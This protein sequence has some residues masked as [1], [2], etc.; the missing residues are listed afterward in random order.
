M[1]VQM[2]RHKQL[3]ADASQFPCSP[4]KPPLMINLIGLR[5]QAAEE[6]PHMY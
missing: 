3:R 6:V 5:C 2:H 1:Q 4:Q